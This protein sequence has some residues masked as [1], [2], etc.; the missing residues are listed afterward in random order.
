VPNEIASHTNRSRTPIVLVA[1]LVLSLL[2]GWA[3]RPAHAGE[4][5]FDPQGPAEK[6]YA[7]PL[8]QA[9][10]E[11]LGTGGTEAGGRP[12]TAPL[13]GVGVGE[14]ENSTPAEAGASR[15]SHSG[16]KHNSGNSSKNSGHSSNAGTEPGSSGG[17][18][19]ARG[20]AGVV[21][22]RF[23][24]S[25][26]SYPLGRGLLILAGLLLAGLAVGVA[27]RA[28]GRSLST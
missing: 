21:A 19:E 13:F 22:R 25:T 24:I 7:L 23:T 14:G 15:P 18:G 6:E 8:Q 17:R 4:V 3:A 28:R 16:S 12:E 1:V 9:R 2:A 5:H 27:L 11:A 20:T 10:G 26:E